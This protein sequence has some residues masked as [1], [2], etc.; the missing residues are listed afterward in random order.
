MSYEDLLGQ[1]YQELPHLKGQLQSPRVV[2]VKAQ[3]KVYITFDSLTLVEEKTFLQLEKILRRI[4][5]QKPLALRVV[6]PGLKDDFLRNIG[7]YKQVLTDFLKRNYP[8]SVSW[9]SQI[10]WRCEG[11]RITLT[12][13]DPFSLEYMGRQNVTARLAQ[14]VKDIFSADV[15]V[16][17][18]L[19]GDQE[20]RL[21][22]LRAEREKEQSQA[23]STKELAERYGQEAV[24][25][26]ER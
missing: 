18:T 2:Y 8:A 22:A 5:P 11:D 9:M 23:I 16:E 24:E 15:K 19:A 12:F 10:D 1:I 25:K 21:A 13:P 26:K 3:E 14:A 4:F 6:S 20:A 7:E 17:L